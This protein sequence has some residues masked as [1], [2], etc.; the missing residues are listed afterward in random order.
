MAQASGLEFPPLSTPSLCKV[1][2]RHTVK[3]TYLIRLLGRAENTTQ[4]EKES[5]L[6]FYLPDT[7]WMFPLCQ[8]TGTHYKLAVNVISL[9]A[10][11]LP[12]W[13]WQRQN[14]DFYGITKMLLRYVVVIMC[15]SECLT[16]SWV[17]LTTWILKLGFGFKSELVYLVSL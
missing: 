6:L 3:D 14:S 12:T 16:V 15:F 9:E 5:N 17:N 2:S 8:A 7:I 1:A 10:P 4:N 11:E 13:K